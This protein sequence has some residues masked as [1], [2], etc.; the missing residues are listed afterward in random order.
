MLRLLTAQPQ[1]DRLPPQWMI[2]IRQVHSLLQ[3]GHTQ[4]VDAD[5][6]AYFDSIP[7]AES[8]KSVAR[9]VLDRRCCI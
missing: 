7:H 2:A 9:R 6:A 5:L 1:A 4:V 8:M 3:Q